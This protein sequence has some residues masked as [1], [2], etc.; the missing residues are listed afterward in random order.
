M[1]DRYNHPELGWH[2]IIER[3]CDLRVRA[4]GDDGITRNLMI[5][6]PERPTPRTDAAQVRYREAWGRGEAAAVDEILESHA[7]LERELAESEESN[8]RLGR[9]VAEELDRN[10]RLERELAEARESIRYM[11]DNGNAAYEEMKSQR[12]RLEAALAEI[13]SGKHS[14]QRCIDE[15]APEALAAVKGK[16]PA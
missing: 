7:T 14:W 16:E 6:T 12:D 2:T 4:I 3:L 1:S 10:E 13:A 15:I 9:K 5:P 11:T 8:T